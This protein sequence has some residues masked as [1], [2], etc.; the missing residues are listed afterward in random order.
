MSRRFSEGEG[1]TGRRIHEL[2]GVVVMRAAAEAV[3][4]GRL[5]DAGSAVGVVRGVDVRLGGEVASGV[6]VGL[7]V[8]GTS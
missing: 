4:G 2:S 1:R 8:G 6:T 7:V 3:A 5:V